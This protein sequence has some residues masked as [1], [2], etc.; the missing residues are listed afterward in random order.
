[1]HDENCPSILYE[2]MNDHMS[3]TQWFKV[4]PKFYPQIQHRCGSSSLWVEPTKG[5][6]D[7]SAIFGSLPPSLVVSGHA[8]QITEGSIKDRPFSCTELSLGFT[9]VTYSIKD[10]SH[11]CVDRII[12]GQ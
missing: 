12:S 3:F 2:Q 5:H 10:E 1:M 8:P 4:E 11:R 9:L 6:F 7:H